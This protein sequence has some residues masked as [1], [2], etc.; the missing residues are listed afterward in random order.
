MALLAQPIEM[1]PATGRFRVV[2]EETDHRPRPG[3]LGTTRRRATALTFLLAGATALYT[4]GLSASG[5][6]NSYYA[7]A[8]QAGAQSWRAMLFGGL[9]P[10][11]GITVDKPPAA[12]WLM[13]VSVRLFGLSPLAILLPQAL[14]GVASVALLYATVRR[15]ASALDP[16]PGTG[17]R[18]ASQLR[19][20][21][22]S[23]EARA[24]AIGLLAAAALAV[25]PVATLMARYDNPDELMLLL[26][27]GAAYALT[28]SIEAPSGG[29]AWLVLSGAL[30]GFAFLTKMLQAW[31][32]LPAFLAVAVLAGA[33]SLGLRLARSG[34]AGVVM[35]A[36]AGWWIAVVQ[37]TP[38]T[39][40]PW[41]GGTQGNSILELALGYNGV[42]RLTG[43][44]AGGGASNV[45]QPGSL[46]RLVGAW[47]TE[48]GWLLPAAGMALL[49]AAVL[50]RGRDRRD[51]LR[52]GLLLW[53]AWLI[54]V[55]LVL[56]SLHGIAHGYYTVQLAPAITGTLALGA[57]VLWQRSWGTAG[58]RWPRVLLI[59]GL[60]GNA[61]WGILLMVHRQ[62]SPPVL[63]IAV[64]AATA[65]VGS[66]AVASTSA[67][68][69]RAARLD[70]LGVARLRL[71]RQ[72]ARTRAVVLATAVI[73]LLLFPAAWSVTT[74]HA[75]HRGPNVASGDGPSTF[76]APPDVSPG[77]A[78]GD[79]FD[80]T[81]SAE[82]RAAATGSR[83]AAAVVGHRAADLQLSSDAPVLALGGYSGKDPHPTLPEFLTAAAHRQVH[84]LVVDSSDARAGGEAGR[85]VHWALGCL[86][87]QHTPRWMVVDLADAATSAARCSAR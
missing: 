14:A 55:A 46:L 81:V 1:S 23:S 7:A 73:G 85:I 29:G 39:Q 65:I 34:L 49:A 43:Q 18:S 32:V 71:G 76:L 24:A 54:V 12:L 44:E 74:A 78:P 21:A 13:D 25:T 84:Y 19:H 35:L 86:P 64:V 6:A 63:V 80:T 82:V 69:R 68:L 5:W 59:L 61:A 31:L 60:L 75:A 70:D 11:G 9:D 40:R 4:V 2:A 48:A 67:V 36:A 15:Q 83:W 58:V 45:P 8:A 38:A 10:S 27:V 37:L 62:A 20:A 41:V 17:R 53:G 30:L 33:G 42:G 51:P 47:G 28:R 77:S 79:G 66:L 3:L 57:A 52:A 87:V 26:L 50:T 56:G 16:P 22:G 72:P